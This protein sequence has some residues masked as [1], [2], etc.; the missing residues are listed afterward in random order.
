[1]FCDEAK[2]SKTM[3]RY[4][5]KYVLKTVK[6]SFSVYALPKNTTMNKERYKDVLPGHL[7]PQM[8]ATSSVADPGWLSRIRLFSIPDPGSASKNLSILTQTNG[9]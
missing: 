1:M 4:A 6:H 8:K 2:R 9:F 3:D 5:D 7:I